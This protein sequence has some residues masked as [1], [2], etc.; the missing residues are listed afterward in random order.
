[1]KKFMPFSF[2]HKV[3]LLLILFMNVPFFITGYMAK[4]LTEKTIL[5]EKEVYLQGLTQI[6]NSRLGPGGYAAI[7]QEAGAENASREVKI[8]VLNQALTA[9]TDEVGTAS[10][11]LGV[12]YY[13]RELDAILT[14]GPAASFGSNVGVS[15][16]QDHPGRIVMN[17]NT[18][19][20][21]S[22]TMVRGDIMNAMRPVERNGK[23]IGY[24]WANELTTDITKQLHD[25]SV[26]I[27]TVMLLCFLL[28]LGI[29][30]LLS[31]RTI[32]DADSIIK[33]VREMRDDLSRRIPETEGQL[34]DVARSI[35]AMAADVGKAN[36][37]T[38]RAVSALQSVLANVEAAIYVC[39]PQTK[40]LVYANDYLC[41]LL[42]R[43]DI[44]GRRCYEALHGNSEP[45]SFCPQRQLFD[46][47]GNPVFTPLRW[48]MYSKEAQRDF[49]ITDRLVT[50]HDGRLLHMEVATDVTE[51][52][53]LALAEATNLAQR[54]FLA[55]M[56]HEIRTPMNGVLGM[57]HLAMQADPPPAQLEYLKKI[58]SSA[59]LLLGI[60]N[61]ILD[62]SRIE[63][64]KLTIEKN[65][66]KPRDMVENI[67]ELIL[68]N[69]R[70]KN[71]ELTIELDAS[72]PE[73]VIGDELRLS[74]VLLNL[75]GNAS[76][77]TL[78]GH[79]SLRMR[80]EPLPSGALRIVCDVEDSGIG[81]TPE[82]QDELFKPFSQADSST[83][84]KFG[85]TGLGLSISKTLVTLM[86]G[87]I[88]VSS[89][90]GL[91]SRFFFSVEVEP[92]R[93]GAKLRESA[94]NAWENV[95]YDG[96]RILLVEDNEINQE[97]SR[98]ILSDL[99][100]EVDIAEN[101]E[102]GLN[103]FLQKDYSLIFMDVRMPVMDGLEA[104]RRIRASDK[105]DAAKVP[106]IA[107]TANAMQED[108][109][110][111]KAAGM[112]DH[113]AKPIEVREL[114][115]VLFRWLKQNK[116]T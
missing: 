78:A 54:D 95:V 103:A 96:C 88:G 14:Y 90:F 71:L 45:C 108:R 16:P 59:N 17:T 26:N 40:E 67:R 74:Q 89:R 1:M 112:D 5:R 69:A 115:K 30:I 91:G 20:V 70:K 109:D 57:T 37:E 25:M 56:S 11:G 65:P 85:G 36:E 80:A 28:T 27:F 86:G 50:W 44:T 106:I 113:L 62:F 107:M 72:V 9:I 8:R 32:R 52:K 7:L 111:T 22:G 75:L 68:P 101:G 41:K 79:I 81:M 105:P 15:I 102:A 46:K 114:K 24:I 51:R 47:D 38:R 35:N 77:F 33:G 87:D 116:Q 73:Y 97:I 42:K 83:S 61:D 4:D 94:D 92:M 104:T 12:G 98:T 18:L 48:E 39:D 63:A 34:G 23:V 13:S 55:R 93:G 43:D 53:A 84:R 99:G 3:I 58:Q 31:R 21:R 66:F 29:L 10:P 76:K 64:G 100:A 82:Q 60:I 49:L 19:L 6:L 110:A 2:Q